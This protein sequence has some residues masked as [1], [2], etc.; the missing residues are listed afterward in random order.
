MVLRPMGQRKAYHLLAAR[1]LSSYW[2]RYTL[3]ISRSF[4]T[5]GNN[6]VKLQ[7]LGLDMNG[8]CM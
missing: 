2:P 3:P 4:V 5:T 7:E 1:Y 6:E 8:M